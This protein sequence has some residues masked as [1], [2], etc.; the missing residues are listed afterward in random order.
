MTHGRAVALY[1]LGRFAEAESAFT[2]ALREIPGSYAAL[3]QLGALRLSQGRPRDARELLEKAVRIDPASELARIPLS[4]LYASEGDHE[5]A[6]RVLGDGRS[7]PVVLI[8]RGTL[9]REQ[10]RLPESERVLARQVAALPSEGQG[11]V[12]LALTLAA[13]GRLMRAAAAAEK[14]VALEPADDRAWGAMATIHGRLGRGELSEACHEK[15]E[16]LR[17]GR[18]NPLTMRNYRR[19][20]T[21]LRAKGVRLAVVQY[22]MRD[23]APLKRLFAGEER[24]VVF[25]D[26]EAAFQ[27]AVQREGYPA[28]FRDMFGGDFGHCT[29]K[30]N[31]L[32]AENI[33]GAILREVTP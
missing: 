17:W 32:L 5:A 19:L 11:W 18:A 2:E 16:V 9:Y 14:A 31:R 27:D 4:L 1:G 22:P 3:A 33:A 7:T 20:L 12:E 21:L 25:V 24:G 6:D 29:E 23:L 8:G 10:G 13:E 26:N 15:A 30:G 28:Y